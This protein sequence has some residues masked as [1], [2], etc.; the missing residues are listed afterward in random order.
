[1]GIT[2]LI[3]ENNKSFINISSMYR[4]IINIFIN[5][6]AVLLKLYYILRLK[7]NYNIYFIMRF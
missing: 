2:S 6:Y 1:M 7:R 5:Q 3:N 4:L